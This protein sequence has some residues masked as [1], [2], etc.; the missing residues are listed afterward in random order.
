MQA[1]GLS[2]SEQENFANIL[3]DIINF[4]K[5]L[6]DIKVELS[7]KENFNL[8]DAFSMLDPSAKGFVSPVELKERL[9]DLGFRPSIDE[10]HLIF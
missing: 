6:E 9:T 8:I 3:I 1:K 10:I 2:R 4:E 5:D 7:L